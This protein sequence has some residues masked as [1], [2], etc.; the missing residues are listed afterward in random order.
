[1]LK[2]KY[3]IWGLITV[4]ILSFSVLLSLGSDIYR[5]APPLP[6]QVITPSGKVVY[7]YENI[8]QGQ[9]AWRSM[10]GMQLGS[11]WGHGAYLAPDW[12]ADWVHRSALAWLDITAQKE[13]FKSFDDLDSPTRAMLE[14]KLRDD[15]RTNG[16]NKDTNNIVISETQAKAIQV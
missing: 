10:G 6:D 16:Y 4:F 2:V 8:D 7:T 9:Q 13:F 5:E 1:M 15:I 12:T 3:I 14:Q 11:I